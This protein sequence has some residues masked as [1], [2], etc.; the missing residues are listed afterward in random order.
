M[1]K[2][3]FWDR[4][5]VLNELVDRGGVK[6]SPWNIS[7][8][9]YKESALDVINRVRSAGF[10]N[11]IVSNQPG[12]QQ[13][14]LTVEELVRIN[15]II[16]AWYRMDDS[17]V[18]LFPN[19]EGYYKP[20][21]GMITELVLKHNIDTDLS[22]MIGDR[23]KDIVAGYNA[24]LKTIFVGN[25]YLPLKSYSSIFPNYIVEKLEEVRN[26]IIREKE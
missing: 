15:D 7:E 19:D 6:T 11:F 18:A 20:G 26:I 21:H 17:R 25:A 22:Y 4:D 5:G 2:A 23:N 9:K 10:L 14:H 8:I 12:V 3:I 13:H 1:K 24:G 16:K